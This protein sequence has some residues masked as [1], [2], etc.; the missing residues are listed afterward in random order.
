MRKRN[1]DLFEQAVSRKLRMIYFIWWVTQKPVP[2]GFIDCS[3]H[4]FMLLSVY[5]LPP[6]TVSD[7]RAIKHLTR[8]SAPSCVFLQGWS[9]RFRLDPY[10]NLL[11]Q[12]KALRRYSTAFLSF[13]TV[14]NFIYSIFAYM[15]L[16][17]IRYKISNNS[18]FR[19]TSRVFTI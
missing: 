7:R 3:T 16:S 5:K 13:I 4:Y 9:L 17:I 19:S 18:C 14:F 11:P 2:G 1:T 10:H 12:I 6:E 15:H 8:W